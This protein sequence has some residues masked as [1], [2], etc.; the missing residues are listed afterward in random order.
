MTPEQIAARSAR[1]RHM[2]ANR[3]AQLAAMSP[4]ERAAS[5]KSKV[6]PA[7]REREETSGKFLKPRGLMQSDI[8]KVEQNAKNA[9]P[10]ALD[11]VAVLKAIAAWSPEE[12]AALASVLA[13]AQ[14][15]AAIIAQPVG[16]LDQLRIPDGANPFA[17]LPLDA[18]LKVALEAMG[19][20]DAKVNAVGSTALA[21]FLV[22][23]G[24]PK[25]QGRTYEGDEH[26]VDVAMDLRLLAEQ[27]TRAGRQA[28]LAGWVQFIG[29]RHAGSPDNF[30][31][32]IP[33]SA[34]AKAIS[35]GRTVIPAERAPDA[36]AAPG[37][38]LRPALAD[39][40]NAYA[41]DLLPGKHTAAEIQAT[42]PK[43]VYE[44]ARG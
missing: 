20:T 7:Q 1:A 3:K 10:P 39:G 16:Q 6:A 8:S 31:W 40:Q 19:A 12:R 44:V 11:A 37:T 22:K 24:R 36:P 25:K 5:R 30:Q 17:W 4:E 13:P 33:P 15:T 42:I 43:A 21:A 14:A 23:H 41:E 2:A 9:H 18:A 32:S 28:P 38:P 35:E 34:L 26:T 29:G 27:T